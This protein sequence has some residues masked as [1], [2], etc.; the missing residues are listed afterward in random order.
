MVS[1][2]A[3]VVFSATRAVPLSGAGSGYDRYSTPFSSVVFAF[4]P[5][6]IAD[7]VQR[8]FDGRRDGQRTI[9][10]RL[11]LLRRFEARL[12]RLRNP[13]VLGL[14]VPDR[15]AQDQYHRQRG[16]THGNSLK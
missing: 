5:A 15:D 10:D 6:I 4:S 12:E 8:V 11:T 16:R 1:W 3:S 13:D 7:S 9:F 2:M 14:R